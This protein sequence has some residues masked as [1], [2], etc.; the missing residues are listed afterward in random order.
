MNVAFYKMEKGGHDWND[1]TRYTNE[2][3][4]PW[5]K[6]HDG[7]EF[8]IGMMSCYSFCDP[9]PFSGAS[10]FALMTRLIAGEYDENSLY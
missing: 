5:L 2:E 8:W 3:I 9:K 4:L 10:G 1:Y 7:S 6:E